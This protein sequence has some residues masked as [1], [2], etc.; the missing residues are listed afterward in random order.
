MFYIHKFTKTFTLNELKRQFIDNYYFSKLILE[1]SC[2]KLE[3]SSLR[4]LLSFCPMGWKAFLFFFF[5]VCSSYCM[6]NS[7]V[8]IV[9]TESSIA[10]YA[11][12][13]ISGIAIIAF[14]HLRLTILS[15]FFF[16]NCS[17]TLALLCKV[18]SKW[19]L[20]LPHF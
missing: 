7:I 10:M 6:D 11:Y 14:G 16:V 19:K 8:I 12:T 13:S 9:L 20:D 5:F 1:N 15:N 17:Q 3:E 18:T 2:S 4:L